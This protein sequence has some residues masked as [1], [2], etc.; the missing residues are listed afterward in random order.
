MLHIMLYT[1]VDV[2]FYVTRMYFVHKIYSYE[3]KKYICSTKCI[4]VY[5]R[6]CKMTFQGEREERCEGGE[7]EY[8]KLRKEGKVEMVRE[9]IED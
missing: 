6:E 1:S 8:M 4:H 9:P 7:R 3:N 2:A 5:K